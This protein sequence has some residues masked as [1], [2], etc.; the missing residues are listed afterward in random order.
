MLRMVDIIAKKRDGGKLSGEEIRFFVSGCTS[1]A[2]PDYQTAALLMAICLNDMDMEEATELTSAMAE[3]GDQVDLSAIKGIKVDKHSTGGVGDKTTL[4][5]GPVVAACGVPV[6]KMSGRGLG[7]TGG[8]IDKLESIPGFNTQLNREDFI[9]IVDEIG[10]AVA[11]QTGNLVPADKKLYALRDVTATVRNRALIASSIM[12]KKIAAGAD[13]VV[14]DVKCG[15]GAFMKTVDEA[16]DLAQIMVTIGKNAGRRMAAVITDMDRPLGNAIGNSLEVKEAIEVLSGKGPAD[17][18]EICLTLAA[19]MLQ[20]AGKGGFNECRESAKKALDDGSALEKLALMIRMQGGL[21]DVVKDTS[22]LPKS[23]H[24]REYRAP[25][26]GF[27]SH[28]L[29]DRLGVAAMML[30]AGRV[31]KESPINPSAGITLARKPGD[32]V[33]KGDVL[34]LLHADDSSLF[35]AACRA[36]DNAVHIGKDK[37]DEAPLIIDIIT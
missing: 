23:V 11:G 17:V 14:L 21:E 6:A 4:I 26:G 34:M 20:L 35:D 9:R 30:G 18:R 3:S 24:V 8:T 27:I 10:I 33:E 37:P 2:I 28:M 15:S 25:T 29:S 36:I 16:R 31:T 13:A 7:H 22:L 1:G 5:V 12:S 19:M 32:R